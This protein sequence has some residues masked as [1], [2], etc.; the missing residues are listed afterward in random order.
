MKKLFHMGQ[1]SSHT[2]RNDYI[3]KKQ[4]LTPWALYKEKMTMR[5]VPEITEGLG[6]IKLRNPIRINDS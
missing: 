1:N 6:I 2:H 3:L 4:Q 5:K